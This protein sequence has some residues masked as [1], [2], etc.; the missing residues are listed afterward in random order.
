MQICKDMP[1]VLFAICK[2]KRIERM[3]MRM[4][5]IH[6]YYGPGKLLFTCVLIHKKDQVSLIT[7]FMK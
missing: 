5:M 3:V 2:L 1:E 4:V 7:L 6:T